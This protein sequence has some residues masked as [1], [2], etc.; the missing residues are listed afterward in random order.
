MDRMSSPHSW[1]ATMGV[2]PAAGMEFI[3]FALRIANLMR[4][5]PDRLAPIGRP[6]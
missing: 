2:I 5:H 1:L 3:A 6:T 4:F